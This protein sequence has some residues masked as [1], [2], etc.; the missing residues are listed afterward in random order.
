MPVTTCPAEAWV[1]KCTLRNAR[2][3]EDHEMP[4]PYV[5]YQAI[6]SPQHNAEYPQFTPADVLLRFTTPAKNEDALDAHLRSQQVVDCHA[7]STPGTCLPKE[8]I[9]NVAPFD[10][11]HAPVAAA[12]R[13]VGCAAID[14]ASEQDRLAASRSKGTPVTQRFAFDEGSSSLS[15]EATPSA[16]EVAALLRD[17]PNIECLG[18]V[19]QS[20]PGESPSIADA[21]ARAVKQLL[22][23]LG[24][25]GK[26]LTTIAATGRAYG[27]SSERDAPD[28]ESRRV[29][30]SVLLE[31][32]NPA[33]P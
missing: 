26:R 20:S 16:T 33:A 17:N 31:T 18:V 23:S 22:V 21:R 27:P 2:K 32:A 15:P 10:P 9:A 12:P 4:I 14:A 6:Y 13:I 29:T 7:E 11:E 25:E 5:V 28:S 1:G 8:V 3:V 24:V 30:L 19:G